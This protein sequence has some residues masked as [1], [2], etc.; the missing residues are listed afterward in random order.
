MPRGMHLHEVLHPVPHGTWCGHGVGHGDEPLNR[1]WGEGGGASDRGMPAKNRAPLGEAGGGTLFADAC[2]SVAFLAHS[3]AP[4]VFDP[5]SL[6]LTL[7]ASN[8]SAGEYAVLVYK[9]GPDVSPSPAPGS[10]TGSSSTASGQW[11]GLTVGLSVAATCLAVGAFV[12][13]RR[14]GARGSTKG[15]AG[16]AVSGSPVGTS[17]SVGAISCVCSRLLRAV[18]CSHGREVL[19]G[20]NRSRFP[21]LPPPLQAHRQHGLPAWSRSCPHPTTM[22]TLK[23]RLAY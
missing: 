1:R 22:P 23:L 6:P 14:L 12:L 16:G 21:P 10:G 11:I 18:N 2:T 9:R 5:A 7:R 4:Q 8:C 15:K 19:P 13:W 20:S 3:A 17:K